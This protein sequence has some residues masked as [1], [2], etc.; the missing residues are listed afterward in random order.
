MISGLAAAIWTNLSPKASKFGQ[1]T[2]VRATRA[3]LAP[4]SKRFQRAAKGGLRDACGC[5]TGLFWTDIVGN[6]KPAQVIKPVAARL[7]TFKP[8]IVFNE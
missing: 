5:K 7:A 6:E 1:Q 2:S 3:E 8:D 4:P